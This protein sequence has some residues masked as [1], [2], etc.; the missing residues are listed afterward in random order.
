MPMPV[1]TLL[2][3]CESAGKIIYPFCTHEGSGLGSSVADIRRLCPQ[4]AVEA[5]LA[6]RGSRVSAA[7][8]DIAEWV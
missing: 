7:E 2:E 8:K 3:K 1:F 4:A 5:G 6:I